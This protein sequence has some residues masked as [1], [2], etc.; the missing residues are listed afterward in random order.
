MK[1]FFPGAWLL[2]CALSLSL[3]AQATEVSSL[4][5]KT[6]R[7]AV[8][9]YYDD[10]VDSLGKLVKYNTLAR[11]GISVF[12]NPAHKAFKAEL[13]RQAKVL[14]L[15]FTD[16]GAVVVV[17]LGQGR[18][19]FGIVTHGDVQPADPTKWAKS[20]FELDMTSEPG[21]IIGRGTEDDK[22]PI[23]SA[24]Y[25]MKAIKDKGISLSKRIELYVYMAEESDWQPLK[26]FI[27]GHELP[28]VNITLDSE[29]PIVTAEKGYGSIE[30]TFP[31]KKLTTDSPYLSR[32]SGGFF[33]SQ[34]PEDAAA[35]IEN[36]DTALLKRLKA[37]AENNKTLTF[38][39]S[40]TEQQLT[41]KARGTSAHSS[42]PEFGVNAITHLAE[43]LTDIRWPSNA[44]GALVNFINDYLGTGLYGEKFANIAYRDD[45]MGPMTVQPTVLKEVHDGIALN[46]NLRRP[47]GKST[48]QLENEIRGALANWQ[49]ENNVKLINISTSISE[50]FVQKDAPHAK[51]LLSVFSH[52]T[53]IK[54]PQPIAIGGSTNS[55]LFPNAVSFG[56]SMPEKVYS[57]HSE[58]EFISEA[59][60]KL[61]LE[62]YTAVMIELAK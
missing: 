8:E 37:K 6:A 29:Y 2:G 24:L 26:D 3:Y 42:K 41:I 48:G 39:F 59:Q 23:S 28:G 25:A 58:H 47:Q 56:P 40:S 62:M 57:G 13:A 4:A 15:D 33:G 19:R 43:L 35:V 38:D 7:Y 1:S 12:D 61:N 51:T 30:M 52:Y 18:E 17:G 54:N 10:M 36:V 60:F 27:K 34:I 22:G 31:D 55:K 9:T 21:N 50:P 44:S 45:F 49:Q 46:I 11:E 32:F 53:G 16:Y 20:P 14:G 5:D